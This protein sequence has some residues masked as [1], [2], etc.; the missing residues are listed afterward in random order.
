MAVAVHMEEFLEM[1]EQIDLAANMGNFNAERLELAQALDEAEA[2]LRYVYKLLRHNKNAI[3]ELIDR[4][5]VLDSIADQIVTA[6]GVGVAANMDVMEAVKR[7]SDSNDSKRLSDGTFQRDET[8][9][10]TKPA[11]YVAPDLTG[12]Y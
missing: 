7:V 12:L 4:E 6:T 5:A 11:H 9:K 2:S 3:I 1:L 10:I 8:G